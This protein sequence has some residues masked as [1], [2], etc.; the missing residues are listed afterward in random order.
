MHFYVSAQDEV[1]S[2]VY[3]IIDAATI[4]FNNLQSYNCEATLKI[5]TA[6]LIT[7]YGHNSQKVVLYLDASK[8]VIELA[9]NSQLQALQKEVC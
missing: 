7:I 9:L 1:P 5:L 3:L 6:L 8:S 2:I 4:A